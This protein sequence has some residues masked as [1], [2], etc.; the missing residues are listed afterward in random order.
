[1]TILLMAVLFVPVAWDL[2]TLYPWAD[3][4]RIAGQA[5]PVDRAQARV[6]ERDRLS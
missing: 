3:A 2:K 5:K 6:P 4:R 1:M